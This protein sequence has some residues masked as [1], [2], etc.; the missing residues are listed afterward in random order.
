VARRKTIQGMRA[1]YDV[2]FMT[3]HGRTE[4]VGMSVYKEEAA[5][6]VPMEDIYIRLSVISND[7][8]ENAPD[9]PR[10]N[11]LE[12]LTKYPIRIYETN[13]TFSAWGISISA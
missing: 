8:D 10:R 13:L 6:T 2:P 3:E 1:Q 7:A 4:F 12:F 11:P 9:V 5:R